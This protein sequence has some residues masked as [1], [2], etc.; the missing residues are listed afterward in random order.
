MA[1]APRRLPDLDPGWVWL[2]GAGPGDP[3]L[4]TLGGWQALHQAEAIVHDTLLDPALLDLASPTAERIDVGKRGGRPSPR[5]PEISARLVAL[6]RA[7]RRVVRLKGGD[8]FVFGRGPEEAGDLAAAGVPFRIVPG[9]P[10]AVGGLAY[11]GIPLTEGQTA[12]AVT[13]VTGH[14]A[15]GGLPAELDWDALARGAPCLVAYMALRTLPALAERLIAGG[16]A[17]DTPVAVVA[18]AT[19]AQQQVV[20]TTLARAEADVA[21][22]GLRPPA[23]VAVG[24]VVRLR[25]RLDWLT[26][27]LA[28]TTAAGRG[29]GSG[30]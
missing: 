11:A 10:A 3:A 21:A 2:V 17:P 27:L 9:V 23:L 13:F 14:D 29:C 15:S 24:E 28:A 30:P 6:A 16:R 25:A 26:G 4:L 7:G 1:E 20:E 5:Q 8:P 19:T 22:A 12:S 18:S